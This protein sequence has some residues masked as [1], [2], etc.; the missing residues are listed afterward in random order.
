[1][2]V[3]TS[4]SSS[5]YSSILKLCVFGACALTVIYPIQFTSA[6][7][8][9]L[10]YHILKEAIGK[11]SVGSGYSEILNAFHSSSCFVAKDKKEGRSGGPPAHIGTISDSKESSQS[12]GSHNGGS[13]SFMHSDEYFTCK[14]SCF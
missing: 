1:M 2:A 5:S 12:T 6:T 14:Y 8:S 10:K 7:P 3:L 11:P 4:S 13:L 9:T